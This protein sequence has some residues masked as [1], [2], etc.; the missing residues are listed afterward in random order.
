MKMHIFGALAALG[1]ATIAT[2]QGS[3]GGSQASC[4]AQPWTSL[5]CYDD[6]DNGRHAGFTWQLQNSTTDPKYYPG[7]ISDQ[8][9]CKL[10]ITNRNDRYREWSW[11][12]SWFLPRNPDGRK[13]V[14]HSVSRQ[15]FSNVRRSSNGTGGAAG[16][17]A[18]C[19]GDNAVSIFANHK[20]QG[21]Y[22]P[23][24][25]GP[26]ATSPY[27]APP[28]AGYNANGTFIGI[29]PDSA[30]SS[31]RKAGTSADSNSNSDPGASSTGTNDNTGTSAGSDG[32][33]GSTGTGTGSN[34]AGP[35]ASSDGNTG[36]TDTF[37]GSNSGGTSAG[38]N[39]NSDT[40]AGSNGNN[41]NTDT[42]ASPNSNSNTGAGTTGNTGPRAAGPEGDAGTTN[43]GTVTSVYATTTVVSTTSVYTTQT[44]ATTVYAYS[45]V[46]I[47]STYTT[48]QTLTTTVTTTATSVTTATTTQL[49]FVLHIVLVLNLLALLVQRRIYMSD[50]YNRHSHWNTNTNS[51]DHDL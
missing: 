50:G 43:T 24:L 15:Q 41:V 37:A 25:P 30:A 36:N 35:S 6:N 51:N 22:S 20:L 11:N 8:M 7:F 28:N 26:D 40:G 16:G 49:H 2:A 19:G 31:S 10:P 13:R 12:T 21:C 32:N 33:T 38:S 23:A 18:T 44:A 39:S 1:L 9:S 34:S 29:V 5:G 27:V 46:Y 48:Q 47:T 3:A 14:Q 45:N 42:S 17:Y 4:S